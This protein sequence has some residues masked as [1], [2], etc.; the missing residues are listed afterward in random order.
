VVLVDAHVRIA[1]LDAESWKPHPM[2]EFLF[3]EIAK[4]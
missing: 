3:Q 4:P 2:P 1:C